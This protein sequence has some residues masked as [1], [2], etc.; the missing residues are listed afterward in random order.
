MNL[1]SLSTT[2]ILYIFCSGFIQ[3]QSL[4]IDHWEL[5]INQGDSWNYFPGFQGPDA[6]WADLGFDDTNWPLGPS[7]IG[8]GDGD[9]AT[10]ISTVISLFM[11]KSFEVQDSTQIQAALLY[12]D[13]DDAFVA[14]LNGHEIARNNIGQSGVIPGWN[15]TSDT[16]HEAQ[17]YQGGIPENYPLSFS[18]IQS[19]LQQG[20]NILAIE[21]HNHSTTSSDLSSIPFLFLATSDTSAYQEQFPAWFDENDLGF[22]SHLPLISINTNNQNIPDDPKIIASM[23]VFDH[24]GNGLNTLFDEPLAYNGQ[25]AIERRGNSSQSFPKKSYGFETQLANGDNN[26]VSLL[27]LP[28]ENDWVLY[29]PYSDKTFIR[30]A[31][32]YEVARQMGWWAPRTRFCEVFINDEYL[33]LYLLTEKIKWD[34]NRVDIDKMDSNDNQGDSVTGGYIVKVDWPDDG[35]NYDWTSPVSSYNGYSLN[36]QYQYDY[37]KRDNITLYQKSYIQNFFNFFETALAGSNYTNINSGYRSFIDVN[38]FVDNFILQEIGNNIDAYRLSNYYTKTRKSQGGKLFSMPIWDFNL[39]FGNADYGMGWQ[40]DVWAIDNPYVTEVIPFHLKRLR[41]D[42]EFRELLKCRWNTL[43]TS[44][45]SDQNLYSIIDSLVSLIGPAVER[46]YERWPVLGTYVWPNYYIGSTYAEEITFLKNWIHDHLL[47]IDSNLPGYGTFC[48]S[49]YKNKIIFSEIYYQG[50]GAFDPGDWFEILNTSTTSFDLSAWTIK[51]Q[52]NMNSYS[53]PS[54]TTIGP[55]EYL[56][57]CKD[58]TKFQQ[59]FPSVS[60]TL[61]SFSWKLGNSDH[62]RLYDE[63]SY[64]VS[65]VNYSNYAPW[66]EPGQYET[67]ELLNTAVPQNLATSWFAGCPGGSPGGP[68][69]TPCP[70]LS[71]EEINPSMLTVSPVPANNFIELGITPFEP[72]LCSIYSSEGKLLLQTDI[73]N[74]RSKI[75]ITNLPD[76]YYILKFRGRSLNLTKAFIKQ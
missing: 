70:D 13:Y 26:N 64:L 3:A 56:V 36:L 37:P 34:K 22:S 73:K 16:W 65:E 52:N 55:G 67:L 50:G 51:D 68:F 8:F 40:T 44:T 9:D 10:I 2:F 31:L 75:N 18:T 45:L 15:Q 62:L 7:G 32:I 35:T 58:K 30:N 72:G 66:P 46:N 24:E 33:G 54:G 48:Q 74:E 59:S 69:V 38:S 4:P 28:E 12:I 71:V 49:L 6:N 41:E 29:G 11:R 53:F 63:D 76:A 23:Q 43:R 17:L 1:R 25:I 61:G 39:A 57:I 27:G 42:P 14:Y 47:W 5:T 60:N 19:F 21:V 20:E